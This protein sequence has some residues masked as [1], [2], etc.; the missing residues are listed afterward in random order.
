MN[1]SNP[2]L[3]NL[4]KISKSLPYHRKLTHF[5]FFLSKILILLGAKSIVIAEMRDGTSIKVDLTTRTEKEA[6]FYRKI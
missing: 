1:L 5:Y 4:S 3:R 2:I 6:F